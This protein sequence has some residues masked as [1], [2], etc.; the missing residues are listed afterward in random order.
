PL[1]KPSYSVGTGP[2]QVAIEPS[3]NLLYVANFGSNKISGFT[4]AADGS[5][6][7]IAG[8]P[9]SAV[10][11]SPTAMA[12]GSNGR[13]LLVTNYHSDDV[14]VLAID[15]VTGAL[16]SAGIAITGP[17]PIDIKADSGGT[18]FY[19]AAQGGE[20]IDGFILNANGTLT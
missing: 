14:Q 16:V 13:Y 19:V 2:G 10:G 8:S 6:A 17:S 20:E 3:Q 1:N 7:P 9:F 12:F 15:P 4:M 11:N 18:N 5:L